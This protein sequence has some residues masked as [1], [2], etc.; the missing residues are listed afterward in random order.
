[1]RPDGHGGD[2]R[3]GSVADGVD[4]FDAVMELISL[5]GL[6]IYIAGKRGGI[7]K[8]SEQGFMVNSVDTYDK[9]VFEARGRPV[10]EIAIG[11]QPHMS[12]GDTIMITNASDLAAMVYRLIDMGVFLDLGR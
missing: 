2:S 11:E 6:V 12:A 8:W 5:L 7:A 1:M 10:Y 3:R 9:L 4:D